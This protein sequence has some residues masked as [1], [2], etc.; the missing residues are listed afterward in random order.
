MGE[1]DVVCVRGGGGA[2]A[3]RWRGGGGAR[4]AR[5]RRGQ[6]MLLIVPRSEFPSSHLPPALVLGRVTFKAFTKVSNAVEF[7][8]NKEDHT[9]G[10]TLRMCAPRKELPTDPPC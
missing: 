10:N 4:G 7:T 6:T 2:V 3:G 5:R 9:L 1:L 8:L